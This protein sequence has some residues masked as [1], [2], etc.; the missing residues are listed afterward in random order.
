M[1]Y[2]DELIAGMAR[3]A[4]AAADPNRYDACTFHMAEQSFDYLL[5]KLE[6]P[7]EEMLDIGQHV[8]SEWLND[9]APVFERRYREP[10]KGV[11]KAMISH[12]KGNPNDCK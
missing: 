1:S 10:A 12:L 9:C 3:A 4:T 5:T 7:S 2:R 8:N 6:Q 11:F